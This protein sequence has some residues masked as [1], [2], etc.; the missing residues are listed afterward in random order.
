MLFVCFGG[1]NC[2]WIMLYEAQRW[3][4]YIQPHQPALYYQ[5]TARQA[6]PR[7]WNALL[8]CTNSLVLSKT[9]SL[10]AII[11]VLRSIASPGELD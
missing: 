6:S 11:T 2:Y 8:S 3:L 9:L 4:K 5:A 1:R 7:M 10:I